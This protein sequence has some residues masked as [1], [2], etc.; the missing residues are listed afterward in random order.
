LYISELC[1]I[2]AHL[3]V[4][5]QISVALEVV[6]VVLFFQAFFIVAT[7][8]RLKIGTKFR[9]GIKSET[10]RNEN[11]SH[12]MSIRLNS[13]IIIHVKAQLEVKINVL[14][15]IVNFIIVVLVP[16]K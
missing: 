5:V 6:I 2:G 13:L 10:F 8:S 4:I 1:T 14:F 16:F 9:P 11:P 12:R 7:R 3:S 15:V